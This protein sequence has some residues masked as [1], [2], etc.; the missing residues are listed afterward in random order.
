MILDE[1][2]GETAPDGTI[3]PADALIDRPNVIRTRTFSKAYGMAGS[4]IAYV[5]TAEDVAA[6]LNRIGHVL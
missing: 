6:E 1:A 3:P 5:I 2:Y 4:R